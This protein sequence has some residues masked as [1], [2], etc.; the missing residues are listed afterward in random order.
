MMQFSDILAI[1]EIIV[2]ILFG[3]YITHWVSV[4]DSRTRS[5]K[6]IYLSQL[7]K[8]K[9]R[10]DKFFDD[11][12][13]GKM[14]GRTIADWYGHQQSSLT[15]FDDGLRLALPIR[16]EKLEDV[17]NRIHE[18]IT[19]SEYFNEH[20]RNSRYVLTNEE[21]AKMISLKN[22]VDRSFNEYV[23]QINN[24]R[25]YYFWET[26]YQNVLFDKEYYKSTKKRCP[27]CLALLLRLGKLLPW[28]VLIS[29][30]TFVCV[31]AIDNYKV[32]SSNIQNIQS[33]N[34]YRINGIYEKTDSI[35]AS[36][37]AISEDN[38]SR[39]QTDSMLVVIMK[40]QLELSRQLRRYLQ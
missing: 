24:S 4:R 38:E 30:L 16:K 27:L 33:V 34:E 1:I 18:V 40:K 17:V 20:F 37:K 19:G 22:S 7:D 31:S 11:L 15:C 32:N 6:D 25:Q 39:I 13:S 12:L 3:F 8:I 5:V 9:D 10:V 35:N 14:K 28:G 36:L 23:V 26:L 21:R 29:V 2:T